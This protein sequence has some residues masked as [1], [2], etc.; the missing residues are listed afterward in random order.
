M[1]VSEICVPNISTRE[2][3]KRLAFGTMAF[4]ISLAVLTVLIVSG[5]NRWW[6]LALIP[7]FWGAATGYFQWRDET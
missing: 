6:R 5:A 7:L 3:H 2:R 1:E 4:V